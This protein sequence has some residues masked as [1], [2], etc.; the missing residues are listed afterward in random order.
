MTVGEYITNKLGEFGYAMPTDEIDLHLQGVG[1]TLSDELAQAN[2]TQARKVL[3]VIIPELLLL[4]DVSEGDL[5]IKRDR[6]AIVS[7]Y[8]MLCAQLGVTD[9]LNQARIQNRSNRW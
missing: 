9:M 4:P 5:S 7:Y 3:L 2:L 6:A 1:L 8:G